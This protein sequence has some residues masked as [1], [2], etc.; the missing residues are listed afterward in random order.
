MKNYGA[1]MRLKSRFLIFF[2]LTAVLMAFFSVLMYRVEKDAKFSD[3]Y[4]FGGA[5]SQVFSIKAREN[6]LSRTLDGFT[7]FISSAKESD[8]RICYIALIDNLGNVLSDVGYEKENFII[9]DSP[10]V[11]ILS[12]AQVEQGFFEFYSPVLVTQNNSFFLKIGISTEELQDFVF[13]LR[14]RFVLINA[15]ILLIL[16]GIYVFIRIWIIKPVAILTAEVEKIDMNHIL[17]KKDFFYK[18]SSKN[19]IGKLAETFKKTLVHL[20]QEMY[21][22]MMQGEKIANFEGNL[23][24][25]VELR[26]KELDKVN[27]ALKRMHENIL[28]ELEMAKRVQRNILPS[29]RNF[30]Q[31]KEF[32]IG[33]R[34]QSMESLGGD[35]YDVIRI[36]K[37]GYGFLI[38]DVSGHG[39]A[40]ALITTM[41][42]VAFNSNSGWNIS[43]SE[44]CKEVNLEMC[45]LIGDLN[46]FITAFYATLN[47]ETG[48]LK[49]TNAGHHPALLFRASSRGIEELNTRGAL[50]G[51][52]ENAVYEVGEIE[53]FKGDRVM[54]YTDGLVDARGDNEEFYGYERLIRYV[55]YNSN[56]EPKR[57]V[58]GLFADIEKF[59]NGHPPND[60]RAI[61]YLEF[62]SRIEEGFEAEDAVKIAAREV[63]KS[64]DS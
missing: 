44:V 53:L 60:D 47:L 29:D 6:I 17:E 37:N 26:T 46:Y 3:F 50:L 40:A 45:K 32:K 33:S 43:P 48:I 61:L 64:K 27:H 14:R 51:A 34:Y 42:K 21:S 36:G 62:V 56:K 30:I 2:V 22:N 7:E 28:E 35:L 52:M 41:A 12:M 55:E 23:E 20:R 13:N 8:N 31:R 24:G 5:L 59:C 19:E 18:T 25:I 57:F 4:T 9:K 15:L 58:D 16:L 38:A 54:F 10:G 39:V 49:F 63:R 1:K 11:S